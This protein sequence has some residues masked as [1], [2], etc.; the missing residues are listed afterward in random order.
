MTNSAQKRNNILG[1]LVVIATSAVTMLWLL[2]HHPVTTAI[3]TIVVLA[4]FAISARL[5]Q[6]VD[7]DMSD[8]DHR[9]RAG[10]H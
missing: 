9:N 3:V 7:T 8:R 5:A 2:W 4:A 1:F 6:M 10:L